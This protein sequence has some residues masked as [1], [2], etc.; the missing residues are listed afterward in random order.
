MSADARI[1]DVTKEVELR[2]VCHNCGRDIDLDYPTFGHP[3]CADD[4]NQLKVD[5]RFKNLEW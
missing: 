3:E 1:L 4:K 5:Y 2:L